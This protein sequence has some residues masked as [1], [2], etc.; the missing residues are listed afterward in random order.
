MSRLL[1]FE[2]FPAGEVIRF[3]AYEVTADEVKAFAAEFDPQPFHLDEYAGEL[4]IAGALS[5]SG[6]HTLSMTMRMMCDGYVNRSASM[7]SFGMDE[8]KW[9]KP[10]FVGDILH[11][12]R[13]TLDCRV[14]SKRPEMGIV[15]FRWQVFDQHD[16]LKLDMRGNG[17]FRVRGALS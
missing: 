3:G 2:D 17:L 9:V 1:H 13:T 4:S 11:V 6:W 12:R 5:A 8:V 15:N 7:G 10:V 14:S 16:V